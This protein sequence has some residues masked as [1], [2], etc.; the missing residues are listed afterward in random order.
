LKNIV[1]ASGSP[2]RKL[3]LQ[4]IGLDF[5]CWPANIREE[6]SSTESPESLAQDLAFQKAGEVAG[7]LKEGIVV[8]ADTLVVADTTI[9]GKPANREEAFLMLSRLNGRRHQVITGICV[10]DVRDKLP[11]KAAE[12]TDVI[13]R[14][15]TPVEINN[16]LNSGE[17]MD[18]AGSYAIQGRGALLVSRIEGCYFNVVGLPL[19][20]LNLMLR[21]KGVDL[22]G[23]N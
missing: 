10:M 17:W 22:L 2:R 18:K 16:Y 1:L 9:M 8:A 5:T 3:L 14:S 15:L 13:F 20:R 23:V 12:L 7:R 4:Q 11:D 21:K 6:W 19:S